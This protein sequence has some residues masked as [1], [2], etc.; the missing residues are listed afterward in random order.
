MTKYDLIVKIHD[1]GAENSKRYVIS[2][3]ILIVNINFMMRELQEIVG[4]TFANSLL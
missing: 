1:Q 3:V 4:L 2:I